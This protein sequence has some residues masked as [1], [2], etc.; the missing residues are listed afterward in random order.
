MPRYRVFVVQE[1]LYAVDVEMPD[2]RSARH[3]GFDL[4]MDDKN[5]HFFDVLKQSVIHVECLDN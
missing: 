4:V 3:E 2:E 1:E 5:R